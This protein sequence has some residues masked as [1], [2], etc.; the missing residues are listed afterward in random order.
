MKL[1]RL[2]FKTMRE[3]PSD[4]D[5]VSG[6][7]LMRAGIIRKNGV[8]M[9]SLMPM[10]CRVVRK[11]E[12]II[13][14]ETEAAGGQE[15]LPPTAQPGE[16]FLGKFATLV[17]DT[18][19]SYR[20][21]PLILYRIGSAFREDFRPRMG[22]MCSRE[23]F[24]QEALSFDTGQ[25]GLDGSY[26]A[27]CLAYR[28]I[29]DRLG[30]QYA[31]TDAGLTA[32]H[33]LSRQEFVAW[34][35]SGESEFVHCPEC[36][37]AA[38]TEL[39]ECAAEARCDEAMDTPMPEEIATPDA[40]TIA[41]VTGFLGCSESDLAKTI[42]YSADGAIVAAMVRGDREI[43]EEKL[44]AYLGCRKLELADPESVRKVTGAEVGFVGP[45][46]LPARIIADLEIT[47]GRSFIVG[48]NRTGFHLRNVVPGRDFLAE[49]ADIRMIGK[50][51]RCPRCGAAIGF[52][53]GT[54]AGV[55]TKLGQDFSGHQGCSYVDGTGAEQ[56]MAVG[57]Y[58]LDMYRILSAVVEQNH[59]ENGIRWPMT[60]APYHAVI[61]P[62]NVL[63]KLQ[64]D[65]AESL[66]RELGLGVE[67]LLDDRNERAGIKFKDADLVGIPVRVNVG[68]KAAEGIVELK[69]RNGENALEIPLEEVASRVLEEVKADP[70]PDK[71][72]KHRRNAVFQ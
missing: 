16:S 55:L 39:A 38:R 65:T 15:V 44:A 17:R 33:G 27:M 43:S 62:V 8:G 59:D 18:A 63:D 4:V 10:G 13:R 57:A 40:R 26:Q 36:G 47:G 67:T 68:K 6:Q 48:A 70:N 53:K 42:L 46:G 22:L 25:E 11:I 30:L 69:M 72:Y 21:L 1:T 64:S 29:F 14:D 19:R 58:W 34:S 12:S 24:A 7:L 37:Y 3:T 20:D 35:Q 23:Y 51:D 31:V 54:V 56:P 45:V 61:V 50:D 32:L 66:Y 28:R 71:T 2:F 52:R 9:Y 5:S 49:S 41:E 60:I